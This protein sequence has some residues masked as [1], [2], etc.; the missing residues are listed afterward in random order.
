MSAFDDLKARYFVLGSGG[1]S[2]GSGSSG[3]PEYAGCEVVP[4][5]GGP[6]YFRTLKGV[7]DRPDLAYIYLAGWW[8]DVSC[9]L[10][11]G[12]RLLDLLKARS[13][14]GVDVRVLGWVMPPEVLN[15]AV[16]TS[17]RVPL[18]EMLRV[19]EN[20]MRFVAAARTE[21]KLADKAM[22]NVLS[23]PD[24]AVH[25]KLAVAG[26][27]SGD[28][29]FTGGIDPQQGRNS[30]TW[31]DVQAE[32]RGAA[33]QPMLDWFRAMWNENQGRP[34]VAVQA[35]GFSL[36]T[37]RAAAAALPARTAGAAVAGTKHV[38]SGRTVPRMNFS[39]VGGIGA[40]LAGVNLPQNQPVSWAPAGLTEV[41]QL[42]QKGISGA[43]R[44]VYIEDQAFTSAEIFDWLNSVLK[45]RPTLKVV[46]LTG[47][48]DPT[49]RNPGPMAAGMRQAVN[50]H[51]LPGISAADIGARI[52]FFT[53]R[54]K[55]IHTKST[56]IDDNWAL[57]GSANMMRRS[58]YTDLEH[59]IGFMDE[60]GTGVAAYRSALWSVHNGPPV[61][62]A[63][64]AD[65]ARWFA[66]PYTGTPGSRPIDRIHLPFTAGA[67]P[68]AQEQALLDQLMDVDSRDAWGSGLLS[69][70][71]TA[72]G[73]GLS[74][75]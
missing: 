11:P 13:A 69:L 74:S 9:E 65:L 70:A 24:G 54:T 8:L 72:T 51:L 25:T 59:S 64:D 29:G 53:H 58:L 31:H 57:I 35:N 12:T 52:G 50:E 45:A 16:V 56:I 23:H 10:V 42:W 30:A 27:S 4:H 48:D 20:T 17:G 5:I 39:A 71:M 62:S 44:Y 66:I 47:A 73:A 18:T 6:D 14:A 26:G 21:P 38:Q 40:S 68:S 63:P 3:L 49:A 28:V 1:G 41:R 19:N 43:Q 2:F 60:T 37:R 34:P 36:A 15:N 75:P 67:T 33:V 7:I 55:V 22:L 61:M 46:L 32:V